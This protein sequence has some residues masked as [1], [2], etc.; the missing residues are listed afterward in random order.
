MKKIFLFLLICLLSTISRAETFLIDVGVEQFIPAPEV[1]YGYIDKAIWDCDYNKVTFVEKSNSGAIIKISSYFD[2]A[3]TVSL[4]YVVKYYDYKGFTRSYTGI[5]YYSVQCKGTAP[6]IVPSGITLKKGDTYQ[7]HI[8][9]S[10]YESQAVWSD[11]TGSIATKVNSSGVV[12]AKN[13]GAGIVFATIPNL[14]DRLTCLVYVKDTKLTLSSSVTSGTIERGTEV[15]LTANKS[16]AK[17]YYT[18]DNSSPEMNGDLYTTPISITEDVTLKAIAYD[19]DYEPSDMLTKTYTVVDPKI[20][21]SSNVSSDTVNVGTEVLLSANVPDATIYYTI[22][23]ST[24]TL[25]SYIYKEPIVIE[26]NTTIKAYA[27]CD[28]YRNSDVLTLKYSVRSVTLSISPTSSGLLP[29]GTEI[30]LTANPANAAIFY[31]TDGSEPTMAS[32]LYVQPIVVNQN[33][34][35]KAKAYYEGYKESNMIT[36]QYEV[37][38][39]AA[40]TFFPE[41]NGRTLNRHIIPSVTFNGNIREGDNFND[42]HLL[43]GNDIIEGTPIIVDD[44]LYFVPNSDELETGSYTF[45][46]PESSIICNDNN[47][48][49]TQQLFSVSQS[50]KPMVA[51]G[52]GHS[53][54]LKSDGS[55]WAWGSNSSGQLGNGKNGN[56]IYNLT[57]EMIM[58]DVIYID[59]ADNYSVAIKSDGS[60]WAWGDNSSGQLGDGTTTKSDTPIKILDNVTKVSCGYNFCTAI[61]KDGSLW[62]WGS[63]SF[64]QLGNGNTTS[65][66]KPQKI[67]DDVVM[68]SASKNNLFCLAIKGDKSLWSWGYNSE[69]QL[70]NGSTGM[71]SSPIR[72]MGNVISC[73]AGNVNCIAIKEDGTRWQWGESILS[74]ETFISSSSPIQMTEEF[75][76]AVIDKGLSGSSACFIAKAD[77]SLWGYGLLAYGNDGDGS[78]SESIKKPVKIL[79]NVISVAASRNHRIALLD[80]GSLWGWGFNDY[81]QL[82]YGYSDGSFDVP[83]KITGIPDEVID[84]SLGIKR[85]LILNEDGGLWMWGVNENG[86]LGFGYSQI[87]IPQKILDNVISVASGSYHNLVIKDDNSLWAWGLN[88]NGQIGDGTTKGKS[89]PIKILDNV[90][91]IAAGYYNSFAIKDDNS[92]WAWGSNNLGQLGDGTTTKSTTPK[93]IIDGV[94]KVS[95][96]SHTLAIKTDG[97]LWAWGS[98]SY[99]QI[100]NGSTS[101]YKSSPYKVM[102]N[103]TDAIAGA[104][105]SMAIKSDGTLWCWG[106]NEKGSLG[107]GTKTN[108]L[109]PVQVMEDV[110]GIAS[111]DYTSFA[112]KSDGSLWAWGR[113]GSIM[114]DGSYTDRL[115]PVIIAEDVKS[116]KASAYHVIA[117]KNDGTAW[118]WGV[119]S[120]HSLS[121]VTTLQP[122][123]NGITNDVESQMQITGISVDNFG[124]YVGVRTYLNNL[125][126]PTNADYKSMEWSSSDEAIATVSQRGMVTGIAPGEAILTVKVTSKEGTEF[127]AQCIVTVTENI[128]GDVNGDNVVDREDAIAVANYILKK[129][130][131]SFN[132]SV[133]DV[134]GDGIINI[135]D[136]IAI[137]NIIKQNK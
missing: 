91:Y 3:A 15:K 135:T 39:L 9:P 1:P 35:I 44:I 74:N 40:T 115:L 25:N 101:T 32:T 67:M 87:F 92:L 93:K 60:L 128:K 89:N 104:E 47:N 59:A 72:I 81:G 18:L 36:Q 73:Y 33:M 30:T 84:S 24:P 64:K 45:S 97:T 4:T 57:P 17:I 71:Y 29:A 116:I 63:N 124:I 21:L 111:V 85:S 105:C 99:G 109:R 2:N 130:S 42:I 5:K 125:I 20:V 103:V 126:E 55:L 22:D 95:S 77:K 54:L 94:K 131:P 58:V 65:S 120:N 106:I 82:G 10:S 11:W 48:L 61:L 12:E 118:T 112:I 100:G 76:Y 52:N 98:N 121:P 26:D 137:E 14:S 28:N 7:L 119:N 37:T 88:S 79:N 80:N 83:T 56:N 129:P 86:G 34:T 6:M 51:V 90:S 108:R 62:T 136:A 132:A 19:D 66:Y 102:E 16:T 134:N 96:S 27:V 41:Q 117:I 78:Y 122:R 107:D 127:T 133:A 50:V 123:Q 46:I 113:G 8:S 49:E 68:V 110:I 43:K 38:S 75:E 31:T 69:G 114:G 23:E 70:G 53:L 13:V